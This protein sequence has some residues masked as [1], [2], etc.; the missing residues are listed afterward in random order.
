[1]ALESVT[2]L[3]CSRMVTQL[4]RTALM[5]GCMITSTLG[6]VCIADCLTCWK[7]S[8]QVL[9]LVRAH[10][11]MHHTVHSREGQLQLLRSLRQQESAL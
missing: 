7:L 4:Q 11:H 1:M 3:G 6:V 10:L 2:W 9:V 8:V 5:H